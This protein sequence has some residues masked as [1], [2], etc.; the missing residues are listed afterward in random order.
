M[1]GTTDFHHEITDALLPQADPVFRDAAALDATVDMLDPQPTVV[2]RLVGAVLL[3]RQLRATGLLRRHKDLDLR[4]REG[5]KAEILQQ[6]TP[7]GQ[8]IR[9]RVGNGLLM[10]AA[11][12][13]VAEEEDDEQ[14]IDS[15][16]IFDRMIF[17]LAARTLCLFSRVLGAD[18]TPF[19]PVMGQR[20]DAGTPAGAAARGASCSSSGATTVAAS[21]SET[22][23]R[24][25]RAVRERAGASPRARSAASSAGRRT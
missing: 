18:D 21:A 24:C 3:S 20:G 25:A 4:E 12:V 22:P 19:G 11:T 15:Q 10:D 2:Q 17:F 14:G 1:Q 6:P 9:R 23:S 8:G 5:Q 7:R 16:D 13:G